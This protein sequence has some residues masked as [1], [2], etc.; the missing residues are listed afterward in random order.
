M[1]NLTPTVR[2][3]LILNV[4]AFI[5]TKV[6]PEYADA[7]ALCYI[8]NPSEYPFE[9]Y[10]LLTYMFMHAGPMHIFSNMLGLIFFGS[11]LEQ[12][13]GQNRFL[14]LYL[15]CGLGSGVL[16]L[17]V[18]YQNTGAMVGASGAVFGIVTSFALIFPNMPLQML[19]PPISLKAKYMVLLYIIFEV[20]LMMQNLPGDK[21]AHG[22][23]LAGMLFGFMMIKLIWR[24]PKRY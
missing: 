13:L 15:V 4:I 5:L 21:I 14:L 2:I 11:I 17:L 12:V 1:I 20:S 24:I 8:N 6:Y 18:N 9:P 7:F 10:Q 19:F 23:H 16:S 3:L 22:A